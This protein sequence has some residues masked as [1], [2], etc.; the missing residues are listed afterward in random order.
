MKISKAFLVKIH[1]YLALI[2]LGIGCCDGMYHQENAM[3]GVGITGLGIMF[4][5]VTCLPLLFPNRHLKLHLPPIGIIS[6]VLFVIYTF[7]I[8]IVYDNSEITVAVKTI[9]FLM[10]FVY[11]LALIATYRWYSVNPINKLD[12]YIYVIFFTMLLLTYGAIV[13]YMLNNLIVE[14]LV[15]SYYLLYALPIVLL[16]K[17][18]TWKAICVIAAIIAVFSSMKRGGVAALVL[19]LVIYAIVYMR[20]KSKNMAKVILGSLFSIIIVGLIGLSLAT[21]DNEDEEKNLFERFESVQEDGGSNRDH[22]Y[23]ITW[24]MITSQDGLSLVVGNGYNAVIKDSPIHYSAHNDYLENLYDYGMVGCGLY[25]LFVISFLKLSIRALREKAE[26]APM[27][28]FQFSNY[29]LLSNVSHIFLYMFMPVVLMT[30]GIGYGQI[31]YNSRIK[32]GEKVNVV[33]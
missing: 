20:I 17:S 5:V 2:A 15:T 3:S 22:V 30:Y 33:V 23:S 8:L 1:F 10:H 11:I 21:M 31:K 24:N 25:I 29:I 14:H 9:R 6:F 32:S 19:G 16:H 7:V 28:C 4:S 26:V 12:T 13:M 18:W 27:L